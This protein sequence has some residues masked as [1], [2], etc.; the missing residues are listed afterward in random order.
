MFAVVPLKL[1]AP[2]TFPDVTVAELIVPTFALLVESL[3]ERVV[4]SGKC[5]TPL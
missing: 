5:H 1:A 2:S 3:A 4:P